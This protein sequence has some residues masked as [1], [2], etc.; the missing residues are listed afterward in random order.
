MLDVFYF[1]PSN[2]GMKLAEEPIKRLFNLVLQS[3]ICGNILTIL[4][5][6]QEGSELSEIKVFS[7]QILA[8]LLK[9]LF[10]WSD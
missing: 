1:L 2:E 9:G 7:L 6:K 4:A 3:S 10:L 8:G 5:L